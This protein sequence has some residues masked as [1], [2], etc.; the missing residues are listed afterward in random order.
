MAKKDPRSLGEIR[1]YDPRGYSYF[2]RV[3]RKELNVQGVDKIPYYIDANC[4]LLVR[5]G[6]TK[7]DILEGMD[8]LKKDLKLRWKEEEQPKGREGRR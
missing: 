8:L 3:V 5:K 1:I 7:K 4:V 6:A 2:P